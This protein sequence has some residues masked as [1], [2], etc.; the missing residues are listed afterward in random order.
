MAQS[1][2]RETRGRP[3]LL[4][5]EQ[6]A[7][8]RIL[9]L[10]HPEAP[11][12]ELRRR[13]QDK[14]A[15]HVSART[16]ERGLLQ[17][18]LHR[19]RRPAAPPPPS[20]AAPLRYGYA[21]RHRDKGDATRYPSTSLT[22]GEWDLVADLFEKKG[23]GEPP[24]YPPRRWWMPAATLSAPAVPGE[25]CPRTFPPGKMSTPRSEDGRGKS[26]SSSASWACGGQRGR[27]SS[28]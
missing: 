15:A 13:L 16:G 1:S 6:I 18:G 26:S 20:P 4:T 22:D 3:P 17:A 8:L 5:A 7:Q 19:G 11:V 12:E 14:T 10:A 24:V 27:G 23:P 9:A 2:K 28:C 21:P 25:C